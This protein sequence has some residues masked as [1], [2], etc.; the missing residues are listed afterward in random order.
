MSIISSEER[1]IKMSELSK[2]K[3][4]EHNDL[5]T[6]VAKMDK[7][8][9]KMFELAVSC[10]DVD[11]PPKDHEVYLSKKELFLFFNVTDSNRYS[12]FKESI[13]MMQKQ[14]YFEIN[15]EV[16]K[17]FNYRSIIP[18]PTVEWNDYND[19]V[20]IRF[21]VDIMPYL[22]DLKK[23]FTQYAISDIMELNSKYSITLYKWICM[24]YNQ[25]ENYQY[26][27]IRTEEKLEEMKN[28]I[29]QID[30]LR[31]LTD[32]EEEHKRSDNFE[33]WVLEKPLEEISKHT[34]FNVIYEKRKKGRRIEYIKFFVTKKQTGKYE[35]YKEEQQDP[36]FLEE[37]K[38]EGEKTES[39]YAASMESSYTS[40][41]WEHNLIT[42]QDI[43]DKE[44]MA[45]L[46]K[47]V[48]PLYDE[49][50]QRKGMGSADYH[51]SY[52]ADRKRDYSNSKKN[53]LRYLHESIK[54]YLAR[55][56]M[57]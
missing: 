34:H 1:A 15:E 9:L 30:E 6:S 32:T 17:G 8:P 37:Q 10:I 56:D 31:R 19:E 55:A 54:N 45:G 36:A 57:K 42:F 28:P 35:F 11:N 26:K 33:K 5:I 40:L 53:T 13:G 29:I 7:I 38:N 3:S 21:N 25:Y 27:G 49:L 24:H 47:K 4:V 20:M 52:V 23:N 43:Q 18:I 39:L 44:L 41:L 22:I 14:A 12:R 2:R 50:E 46:Q 51:V 16:G 48:Y